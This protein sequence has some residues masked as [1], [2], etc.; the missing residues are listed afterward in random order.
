VKVLDVSADHRR[1]AFVVRL[2]RRTYTMPFAICEPRPSRANRVQEVWIDPEIGREGFTYRLESGSEGTVHADHVRYYNRDPEY[3][4][5]L[6]SYELTVQALERL[7]ERHWS[8]RELARRLHTSPT[9]VYRLLDTKNYRK[10][11]RQ[12]LSLLCLLDCEIRVHVRPK[13]AA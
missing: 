13:K 2:S 5:D 10:S 9:Q 1:K 4:A 6:A 12:M 8:V 11:M 3:L 7:E